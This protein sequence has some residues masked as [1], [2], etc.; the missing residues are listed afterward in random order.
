MNRYTIGPKGSTPVQKW[1]SS[2]LKEIYVEDIDLERITSV[3]NEFESIWEASRGIFDG[4]LRLV[5]QHS[6]SASDY[7]LGVYVFAWL[8]GRV[9]TILLDYHHDTREATILIADRRI[10]TFRSIVEDVKLEEK[11]ANAIQ[12]ALDVDQGDSVKAIFA[13]PKCGA[14]Y[15]AANLEISEEGLV[16]CQN[17]GE[18]VDWLESTIGTGPTIHKE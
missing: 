7:Q 14:R 5:F 8:E 4:R 11:I 10:R 17:C 1:A 13:C 3:L 15:Q 16:R 2:R 18:W 9:V 12:D 6:G